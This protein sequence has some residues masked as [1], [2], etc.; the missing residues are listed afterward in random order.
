MV[1]STNERMHIWEYNEDIF[2]SGTLDGRSKNLY[3]GIA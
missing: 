3:G 1:S 2:E